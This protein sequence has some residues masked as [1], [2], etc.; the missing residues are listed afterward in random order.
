MGSPQGPS[1]DPATKQLAMHGGRSSVR[2]REFEGNIPAGNYGAGS[3]MLWDT[4]TYELLGDIPAGEQ[5]ERGDLKFRLHGEKLKGEFAIVRMKNR[6]K[7]NEWLLLKKKDDDADPEWDDIEKFAESVS[8]GRTQEEIAQDMPR[9]EKRRGKSIDLSDIPRSGSKPPCPQRLAN[10]GQIAEKPPPRRRMALR[11]QMGRHPGHLFR[12]RRKDRMVSPQSSWQIWSGQYPELSVLPNV[13]A[14][15]RVLDGEICALDERGRPSFIGSSRALWSPTSTPSRTVALQAGNASVFDLL[16][17]DGYDLRRVAFDRAQEAA[18]I[19]VKPGG[20]IRLSAT[21]D[22]GA[23]FS[24]SGSRARLEGV[25]AKRAD[26]R[27]RTRRSRAW[28]KI[29]SVQPERMRHLRLHAR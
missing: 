29:K 9:T 23:K 27:Y 26:S 17:L 8:T 15:D 20:A 14:Q 10:A 5:I 18:R 4:G 28:V 13:N 22:E 25:I 19:D 12:G 7:G 11:N 6:G 16:Y 24:R 3:V 2:L 1:L 21:F